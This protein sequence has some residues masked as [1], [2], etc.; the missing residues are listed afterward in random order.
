MSKRYCL[1]ALVFLLFAAPAFADSEQVSPT[2]GI[3]VFG[4]TVESHGTVFYDDGCGLNLFC[5]PGRI[6]SGSHILNDGGVGTIASSSVSGSSYDNTISH[7]TVYSHCY[8]ASLS[9]TGTYGTTQRVSSGTE[10]APDPPPPPAPLP[11]PSTPPPSSGGG[12]EI[13]GFDQSG[14]GSDPL[15]ISL[16]S[17]Y[18]LSGL[19]Q[20]VA[21]DINAAGHTQMIGWTARISD[22]A[23]LALDLNRNGRIDD[24]SELFG[25]A[26]QLRGGNRAANGFDAIADYDSNGDGVIDSSDE[27]W[28][29]LLLWTDANHNGVSEPA[30]I[31]PISA[32]S[33][34]A[35]ELQHHWTGRHDQHGNRFGYEGHVR[36]DNHTARFYDV[37][38]VTP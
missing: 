26:T 1:L 25:N 2:V 30:E 4:M 9:A 31:Q 11:P 15:V 13:C 27:V 5:M 28:G 36:V 35:I 24:G 33:I 23:F 7:A 6:E 34:K 32:S 3:S 8:S 12:C 17:K 18:E 14:M 38:F 19:D 37:F 10:C 29:R 22:A 21:F 20:P 16:D